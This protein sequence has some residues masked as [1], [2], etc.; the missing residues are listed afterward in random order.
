MDLLVGIRRQFHAIKGRD[1]PRMD[2][3]VLLTYSTPLSNPNA[4][5]ILMPLNGQQCQQAGRGISEQGRAGPN[6][7]AVVPPPAPGVVISQGAAA[8]G[9]AGGLHEKAGFAVNPAGAG[10]GGTG[11][12]AHDAESGEAWPPLPPPPPPLPSAARRCSSELVH[13]TVR[14]GEGGSF[15]VQ[16]GTGAPLPARGTREPWR[17]PSFEA[18]SHTTGRPGESQRLPPSASMAVQETSQ[19][20]RE[21][22]G[23]PGEY[24][25][26]TGQAG[27]GYPPPRP[28]QGSGQELARE[29]PQDAKLAGTGFE[30]TGATNPSEFSLFGFFAGGS[31]PRPAG[32]PQA[33]GALWPQSQPGMPLAP[34][35]GK[36]PALTPP[37]LFA[38]GSAPLGISHSF[39]QSFNQI[40]G[41]AAMAGMHGPPAVAP[42]RWR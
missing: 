6:V 7:P 2:Q 22:C 40:H 25:A 11:A 14:P 18:G 36:V 39:G 42:Q 35:S 27:I 31:Q 23:K 33:P 29:P 5:R 15:S 4:M 30:H 32:M 38:G 12:A 17:E 13:H 20:G 28:Q 10:T 41:G 24:S 34:A 16:G 37:N 9:A 8:P 26:S 21:T 1:L 19:Y 3:E